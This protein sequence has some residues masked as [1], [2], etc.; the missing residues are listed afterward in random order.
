MKLTFAI[1]QLT[2][3]L[4][5]VR[6][7]PVGVHHALELSILGV[8]PY[9]SVPLAFHLFP[10]HHQLLLVDVVGTINRYNII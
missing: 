4:V 8:G 1:S 10:E 7:N 9:A 6:S 3:F 2:V 5:L